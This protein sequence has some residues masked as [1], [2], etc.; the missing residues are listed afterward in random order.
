MARSFHW[1]ATE[2]FHG[3]RI[4]L[5]AATAHLTR[6]TKSLKPVGVDWGYS[7]SEHMGDGVYRDFG[8]E[9]YTIAVVSHGGEIGTVHGPNWRGTDR[10]SEVD[11]PPAGSFEDLA[12]QLGEP[13]LFVDLRGA[14]E[15]SWLR[16]EFVARPLGLIPTR[17][18]WRDVIDAFLF[19][20]EAEP[21][22]L[23]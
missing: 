21:E 1:L 4:M 16:G 22:R 9:L 23:R 14:P 11:T 15:G 5:W 12:H 3:R 7:R 13:Y 2:A 6:N 8:D 20:D 18:V 17:A 10:T 19:I